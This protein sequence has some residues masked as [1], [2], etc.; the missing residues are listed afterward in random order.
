MDEYSKY[1]FSKNLIFP[2]ELFAHLY[3]Q[4]RSIYIITNIKAFFL[5][6][7]YAFLYTP[8]WISRPT[9]SWSSINNDSHH[10]LLPSPA[11]SHLLTCTSIH[12]SPK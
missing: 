3:F 9:L 4:S 5:N 6:V 1:Y 8:D 11:C 2:N 7:F 12:L 10:A